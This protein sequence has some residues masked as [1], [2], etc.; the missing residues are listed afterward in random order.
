MTISLTHNS[1]RTLEAAF[2]ASAIVL[3]ISVSW[4]QKAML[5]TRSLHRD[6]NA[7][8]KSVL[9]GSPPV[10]SG[11]SH[12]LSVEAVDSTINVTTT[13]DLVAVDF[14][15]S[16]ATSGATVSLRSAI[17][18]A[19]YHTSKIYGISVPAG[20]YTLALVGMYEDSSLTGDLD[21]NRS[22]TIA[23]SGASTTIVDG[24]ALDRVFN[25]NPK[26]GPTPNVTFSQLTIRNGSTP[27]DQDGGGIEIDS[28]AIVTL[29]TVNVSSNVADNNGG[30]IDI[31]TKGATLVVNGGTINSNSTTNND[32]AG[33]CF[34]AG[35]VTLNNVQVINN[36]SGLDG[37]GLANVGANLTVNN[38]SYSNNQAPF[39]YGGGIYTDSGTLTVSGAIIDG[40]S[41]GAGG[42]VSILSNTT[43]TNTRISNNTVP[44]FFGG[45]ILKRNGT[46]TM[47]NS[48][49]ENNSAGSDGGGIYI[50]VFS[51]N[52]SMKNDTLRNN[53]AVGNGGGINDA[54]GG[55]TWEGG[56]LLNNTAATNGGGG[57]YFDA[58]VAAVNDTLKNINIAGADSIRVVNN[59]KFLVLINTPL[60]V[61]LTSFYATS[62]ANSV[63]LAW[64]TMTEVDNAGFNVLRKETNAASFTQIATFLTD[65]RLRGAGTSNAPRKYS[66]TDNSVVSGQAYSYKIQ[67]VSTSG[68]TKD[69]NTITAYVGIPKDYALYQNFPN[70]FNPSTTVQFDLK[71]PSTVTLEVFNMLGQN[72]LRENRGLMSAGR[73]DETFNLNQ[74]ASGVYFYRISA[75]GNDGERF[76]SLKKMMLVK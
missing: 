24:G 72:V 76:V 74:N 20:T 14:T 54:L 5:G 51:A 67:S 41:A 40:N 23:G 9:T 6:F 19:N 61:E 42:G 13:S 59:G 56:S 29:D 12:L 45:G 37:G 64:E 53:T 17:Q 11:T 58:G 26:R 66:F 46:L 3:G 7:Q 52:T 55:I 60:P 65:S 27:P 22:M 39:E 49:V 16:A 73:Y 10:S 25:I 50:W 57:I 36:T 43:I 28:A 38:G 31:S 8:A 1:F 48:V 18:F 68:E 70:P 32:G 44:T 30:G 62:V 2:L 75:L 35:T 33:A 4:G 34:N 15:T 71:Q 47:T 69:G 21:I 63:T